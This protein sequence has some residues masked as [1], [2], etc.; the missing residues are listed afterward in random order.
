MSKYNFEFISFHPVNIYS[1]GQV[2]FGP[3]TIKD[4]GLDK[5]GLRWIED[6]EKHV[7][8]LM[9]DKN[10]RRLNGLKI[11]CPIKV[12]RRYVGNYSLVKEDGVFVLKAN[13]EN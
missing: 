11:N 5:I 7:L 4:F 10:G 3:A 6:K 1:T 12:A 2:Y 8:A 9:E 13:A